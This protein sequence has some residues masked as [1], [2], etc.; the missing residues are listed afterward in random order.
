VN[1]LCNFLNNDLL[2]FPLFA[3]SVVTFVIIGTVTTVSN[4][5]SKIAYKYKQTVCAEI[6]NETCG[7][8]LIGCDN[9]YDY[10][11]VNKREIDFIRIEE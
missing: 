2:I 9:G 8:T 4:R 3:A 6:Y 5:N 10:Q 11:C 7:K 1:K